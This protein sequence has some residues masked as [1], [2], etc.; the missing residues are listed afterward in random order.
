MS[1]TAKSLIGKPVERV[2]GRLKVTGGARYAAEFK[3]ANLAHAVLVM[4]TIANGSIRSLDTRAA[5]S[6]PGVLEVIT[7]LNAPRLRFPERP[8]TNDDYVAPVFG[9]SLPVLQDK[10]IYFN[11]QP[12]AVVIAETLEQAEYAATLVQ[13]DYDER[14]PVTNVEAEMARAFPPREGLMKEPPTGRPADYMRGD[15]NALSKAEVSVDETYTIP[16][17]HHN[18]MELLS[19]IAEWSGNKL[20]LHDKTQWVPN[21]QM[22][23]AMVFGIPEQ[24]VRV[25][26]PFVGGAFGSSLRP[27][28]HPIVAAMAARAVGRPV[29]LVVA[30]KQMFTSHGHRPYTIQRVALG[31]RRDGRLT[32]IVHE[33]YAQTSLYEENTESLL[34]ATRMLYASPNCITKYRLVR[35]NVQTPLYMRGPGECSGVFALDSA[36]DELAYKLKIDPLEMRIRNHAGVD[37][38]GNLPWS[39]KSLLECYKRGAEVFGW[40]RRKPEPRSMRDGRHLIGMGMATGTYPMYRMPASARAC[41][42]SDGTAVVQSSASDMGPGT[43]TTMKI[44][45]AE[46]LAMDL[47][48]VRSELGDSVLPKGSVHGGSGTTA[49]V[50]SAVHEAG[51][52]ARAKLLKLAS[53]DSRSPLHGATEAQVT[54]ADGRI[55]LQSD[56]SRGETYADILRRNRMQSIEAT[57]DSK[58]GDEN[59]KFSM[60]AFCA[61][62]LE[63]RVDADLGMLRVSRGVTVCGGGRIMNEQTARSQITGGVVGG[64]G[65]GLMEETVMDHRMGRIVNASLGEYH[66][67]VNADIPSLEAFFVEERDEHV[68]ALGAKGIGEVSY[69][70]VAAALAN[71]VFHATG[72]RIRRLPITLDKLL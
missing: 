48:K 17:E 22:H 4:S 49:S 26:S 25:I 58:P 33:G 72:K 37:P 3:T 5:K 54:F 71:A 51:R 60:H 18:P 12:I 32:A 53:D 62:F 42:F 30:R 24:N 56:P 19:T 35:G 16:I 39:S 57:V 65:M 20:T 40:A 41:I 61:H 21:T 64:I 45:G 13:V 69:V 2:D 47:D 52:A 34:G 55:S 70:G 10:T 15:P 38:E 50:G 28:S 23:V 8:Q 66:V 67:P 68:N 7:H 31:A 63:V 43:W 11:G 27:W 29:K 14:K 59:K 9:R 36:L 46:A 44:V 6:A 1:Q